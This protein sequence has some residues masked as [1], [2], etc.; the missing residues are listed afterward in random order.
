MKNPPLYIL[1][2]GYLGDLIFIQ[3]L[4]K[5][6]G[7]KTQVVLPVLQQFTWTTNAIQY[8]KN[9]Y[10]CDVFNDE[11]MH[12][13]EF[14]YLS[15]VL[16]NTCKTYMALGQDKKCAAVLFTPKFVYAPLALSYNVDK[17][18]QL[19][20]KYN[21]LSIDYKGWQNDVVIKHNTEKE[22]FLYQNV[23]GLH[24][25]EKYILV[26]KFFGSSAD[27]KFLIYKNGICTDL[28]RLKSD[29]KIIEMCT[30]PEFSLFDW[31]KVIINAS[32][33][34]TVETSLCYLMELLKIK[35]EKNVLFTR[36]KD[37]EYG[38]GLVN[39]IFEIPW[40]YKHE[41]KSKEI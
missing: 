24:E 3:K 6:M 15:G 18:N 14:V 34:Y 13:D 36:Q 37:K 26:N 17:Q 27:E 28:E 32:Q 35:S 21:M 8:P 31:S 41:L 30:I 38:F 40:E 23:L 20:E 2:Q 4:L 5:L 33:I 10:V 25:D 11:Y 19:T 9:V 1:Q 39:K 29:I 22:N 12:K 7:E 16:T